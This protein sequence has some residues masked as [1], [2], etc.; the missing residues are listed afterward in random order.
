MWPKDYTIKSDIFDRAQKEYIEKYIKNVYSIFFS[1]IAENKLFILDKNLELITSPYL[2]AFD[3]LNSLI[4][5]ESL[6][7]MYLLHEVMKN[8]DV[9]YSSFF[10]FVDFSKDSKYPRLTFGAPWDF[11]WSSGNVDVKLPVHLM[12]TLDRPLMMPSNLI[13]GFICWLMQASSMKQ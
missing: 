12:A 1:A 6:F 11:D 2:T 4:D 8:I 5:M 13:L 7:K 3:T 10:M 9:G